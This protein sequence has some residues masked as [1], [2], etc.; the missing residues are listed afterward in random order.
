MNNSS[1]LVPYIVLVVATFLWASTLVT[2]KIAFRTYDP[3]VVLF[4]R[5]LVASLCAVFVPS[6][7]KNAHVRKKD[8]KL[9]LFLVLCEPCLYYLF[10]AAALV[11]TSAAQAGMITAI[12]PM[13]TAVGAWIIL[14]EQLSLRTCT[15]FALAVGGAVTLSLVSKASEHGPSPILG[16][17][18]EF[19]AMVC[20]TGYALS[21][22]KLTAR[23]SPF[24]LTFVQAFAGTLFYFPI[25]FFPGVHLP[26]KIDP[27]GLAAVLYLGICVTLG[28]YGLYSY[29]VSRI[30]AS[31]ATAFINLIPVFTLILSMLILKERFSGLQYMA[32]AVILVGVFLSQD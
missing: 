9:I 30:P 7:F 17:F 19:L 16:N 6:L 31:R 1:K 15:G 23:Y 27:F 14:K 4:G 26:H 28:A 22:K 5:M 2:L 32:S 13:M 29:G 24:F 18:L 8:I 21:L 25:L 3:M 10:E 12:M 20:A 11:R